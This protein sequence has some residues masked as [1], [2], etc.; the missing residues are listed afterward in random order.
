MS[1]P[2]P[3]LKRLQSWLAAEPEITAAWLFGSRA[4]G[5]ARP[6]SD[7]DVA[8]LPVAGGNPGT[9]EQR[10]TWKIGAARALGLPQ[11]A[12][13]LILLEQS[14]P[15]LVHAV[16]REGR[17]L[18][19]RHPEVRVAFEEKALR[20]FVVAARLRDEAM[21]ARAERFIGNGHDDAR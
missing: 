15:L 20:K 21:A 1:V 17:L 4:R 3:D 10:L 19:D 9:L 13:D 5:D 14:S 6:D 7:V 16:L 2:A 18:V 12:V 11:D 8:V